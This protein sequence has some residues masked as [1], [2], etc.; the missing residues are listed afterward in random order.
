MQKK[1]AKAT[2]SWRADGRASGATGKG[3]LVRIVVVGLQ[4]VRCQSLYSRHA[5][6]PPRAKQGMR[7]GQGT[8]LVDEGIWQREGCERVVDESTLGNEGVTKGEHYIGIPTVGD[9]GILQ[10]QL[11]SAARDR[12]EIACLLACPLVC[13]PACLLSF[14]PSFTS[15]RPQK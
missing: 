11:Y 1:A 10:E 12:P 8:V 15:E 6:I 5:D 4:T 9:I 3:R 2:R 7:E 13:L 14:L